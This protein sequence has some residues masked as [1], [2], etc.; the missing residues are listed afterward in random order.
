MNVSSKGAELTSCSELSCIFSFG[1]TLGVEEFG[2]NV[3]AFFD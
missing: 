3:G 1:P 2:R